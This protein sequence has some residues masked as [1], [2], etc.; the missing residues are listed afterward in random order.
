VDK[1]GTETVIQNRN[2]RQTYTGEYIIGRQNKI[3]ISSLNYDLHG[4]LIPKKLCILA[5]QLNGTYSY[6]LHL[7]STLSL[8]S[9]LA[10]V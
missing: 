9:V 1:E 4:S 8:G 10:G 3:E 2:C 5:M 7:A 6:P